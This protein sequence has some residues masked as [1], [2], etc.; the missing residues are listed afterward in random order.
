MLTL[1]T[2]D[3]TFKYSNKELFNNLNLIF[4]PHSFNLIMGD[5]G[6]GKSTLLKLI[7]GLKTPT[8]GHVLLNDQEVTL[9]VPAVR[10]QYVTYLPQNPRHFFTFKTAREQFEFALAN[11]ELPKEEIKKRITTVSHK[12]KLNTLLDRPLAELSGGEVQQLALGILLA[13]DSQYLL[14]DEPFTNLDVAHRQLFLKILTTLKQTKTIIITDHNLHGYMDLVDHVFQFDLSQKLIEIP[15]TALPQPAKIV[16]VAHEL[17]TPNNAQLKW[18]HLTFGVKNKSLVKDATFDLPTGKLGL[19]IGSNGSGKTSLFKTLTKQL[20]Y[21]GTISFNGQSETDTRKRKWFRNVILGFQNSEDQFIKTTIH[22][23]L[24]ASLKISHHPQYWTQARLT[25]WLTLLNL[26]DIL[27]ESPY[28]I[29]GGQQKKVQ[30]LE[31]ALIA[32]PVILLDETLTGI[33]EDSQVK[34]MRLLKE[35]N[36]LG[37]AILVIDHQVQQLEQ[38]DYVMQ[39]HDH[40]L[41]LLP[42][43][44]AINV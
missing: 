39:L 20:S 9:V 37:C 23:E 2:H 44:A 8:S 26:K 29:S 28:Y 18:H 35:I 11:L 24:K 6:S 22:E 32:D 10:V 14:L 38:F 16:Y 31:L 1:K 19:L 13:L 4:E 17:T 3:L 12:L 40:Q 34:I 7:A 21:E 42:K 33:D 5:N 27:N 43:E 15:R 41:T 25:K 36:H 30:L